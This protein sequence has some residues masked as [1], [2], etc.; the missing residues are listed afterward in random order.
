MSFKLEQ[1]ID[2]MKK[3][4]L[5]KALRK[6]IQYIKTNPAVE[7]IKSDEGY[8][9]VA[10]GQYSEGD[11]H[12]TELIEY[13]VDEKGNVFGKLR[14]KKEHPSFYMRRYYFDQDIVGKEMIQKEI[15]K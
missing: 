14:E 3:T 7:A 13:T 12:Y 8:N 9:K 15:R 10:A 1:S 5:Q 2:T 11:K 4:D 6:A